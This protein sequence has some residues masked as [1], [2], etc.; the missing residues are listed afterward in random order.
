MTRGIKRKHQLTIADKNVFF[1][2]LASKSGCSTDINFS[3]RVYYALIK[4]LMSHIREK[5]YIELPEFG[6]F[7]LLERRGG[8][9]AKSRWTG[10]RIELPLTRMLKFKNHYKLKEYMKGMSAKVTW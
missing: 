4:V 7:Y 5:G 2:E 10:Q 6:M 8:V 9:V 3:K 1:S